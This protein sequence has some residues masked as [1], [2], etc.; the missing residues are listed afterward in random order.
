MD[1]GE[2]RGGDMGV[3]RKGRGGEI[4]GQIFEMDNRSRLEYAGIYGNTNLEKL[5][6]HT[7]RKLGLCE[8]HFLATSFT[9]TT[10]ERLNR[11]AV[12]IAYENTA[13][14]SIHIENVESEIQNNITALPPNDENVIM[15]EQMV[16]ECAQ[17]TYRPAT[18][19][20]EM[21]AEEEDIME[22]VHLEPPKHQDI[23]CNRPEKSIKYKDDSIQRNNK[24]K[25]DPKAE[26]KALKIVH[27]Y[28]ET[29]NRGSR[30]SAQL[31]HQRILFGADTSSDWNSGRSSAF[32]RL[33]KAGCN[34]PGQRTI[35]RWV[36]EYNIKPGFCDIIFQ[37][38]KEKI[39][40]IPEEER[41]CALKWDE[42]SIKNYEEYS[43]KLDQ[44]EGLVDLGPLGKQSERNKLNET[45]AN[46]KFVTCDQGTNNQAAYSQLGVEVQKP[47]FIY[48]NKKYYASHDFPHLVK[49]LASF[50]RT[51]D[52]IYCK[53]EIIA[54]Y[55]DFVKTWD[56]DNA[57]EG[58]SNLLS[59]IS[60]AHIHPNCFE[61][62]NVKRAFQ[63]FS[64]TFAAA[65]KVAGSEKALNSNTWEATADFAKNM[66]NVIDACNSYSLKVTFG[67]KRPL[68]RK[69]PDIEDLLSK[70]VQWCPG[71]S[72]Y[73]NKIYQV[74]CFKGLCN[75]DS[76][77]H[78]FSKLRQRG[79]FNP[80]PT[81]RMVRLSIRHIL[82]T[83][84][85]QTSDQGN[86][87]CPESE[88][89]INKPNQITKTVENCMS[90][91]NVSAVD[92]VEEDVDD[93]DLVTELL[94]KHADILEEYDVD[95]NN[96]SILSNY[97]ENAITYFAGY[98]ARPCIEKN[99]CEDCRATMLKTPMED[100]T[101]S[102]RY[103]EYREY[104]N[105]DEDAPTVTKLVRPTNLF[106]NVIKTQLISFNRTWQHHWASTQVLEKIMMVFQYKRKTD[107]ATWT[108]TNLKRA[109]DAVNEKKESITSA[110][111]KYQIPYTTLQRH[112]KSGNCTKKLG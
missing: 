38:L 98:I 74:P 81:A 63:L 69:N 103:I 4:T 24:K 62:M 100:A 8:D 29:G 67:G 70:F 5:A 42:M 13:D 39:I 28:A 45:G 95:M 44:I 84:Y 48:N 57:T 43:S 22:W 3:E 16:E 78:L 85:I 15:E 40:Q 96:V 108:E 66:N 73:P 77:E 109:M 102:E 18:L 33:R 99:N 110:A 49:R 82:S 53:G 34:F 26:I 2:L 1:G 89:L 54:S 59:H 52:N 72:K 65:I 56:I 94:D 11:N 101:P 7:V 64:H 60:Q 14:S 32:C 25:S 79:G 90:T 23:K 17:R 27:E 92:D 37:K 6:A 51:H 107:Q 20:F 86:V 111:K 93:A 30:G 47:Y 61:A 50:L 21:S 12:P 75:Q 58:G 91:N 46:V 10:K 31:A 80:N 106:T 71:W 9:N 36:E 105:T 19:N 35:R 83:G 104:P 68:S 112:M 76:V 97:D 88:A 55:S 41:L 87:Q